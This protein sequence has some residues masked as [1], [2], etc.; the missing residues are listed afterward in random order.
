MMMN[1]II[2]TDVAVND[3]ILFSFLAKAYPSP[4]Y[5]EIEIGVSCR[6]SSVLRA[7]TVISSMTTPFRT[8]SSAAKLADAPNRQRVAMA[9]HDKVPDI[10]VITFIPRSPRIH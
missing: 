3:A 9:H 4:E 10:L 1:R 7:V 8:P 6:L 5:A 2:A